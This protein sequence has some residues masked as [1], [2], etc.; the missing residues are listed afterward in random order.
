M[1]LAM[2]TLATTFVLAT[3]TASSLGQAWIPGTPMPAEEYRT[4]KAEGTL[5]PHFRGSVAMPE[6]RHTA[7]TPLPLQLRGGGGTNTCDCWIQ[8][9]GSYTLAMPPDDDNSSGL[10]NLPF[11]FNL[12]GQLFNSVYINNN[13]NISFDSPYVTFTAEPFPVAGFV[14]VAPFWGDV[15]TGGGDGQVWYKTTP[16]ALYVNW[17]GVGYYFQHGDLL[18]SFQLIITDGNDPVIGI[19]KNVSFCY[20]DMQWT[21]GDVDGF[22][23]FGGTPATVGA[24]LGNG[25]DFIQFG[26]FDEPGGAYDGPFGAND[27][28]D[29]LDNQNLVFNTSVFTNNIPPIGSGDYLCDTL[30][31]C[32]GEPVTMDFQFLSPEADQITTATASAPDFSNFTI[33]N[34]VAGQTAH[35]ETQFTPLPTE[36]GY[37]VVTF[38]ATDNGVPPQTAVYN[39]VVNVLVSS[40]MEPGDTV[41]CETSLPLTLFDL[42]GGAPIAGGTWVDPNGDPH[43]GIFSPGE[44]VVG[45]YSYSVDAGAG[46]P[47]TGIVTVSTSPGP[48]AGANGAVAFCTNSVDAALFPSLNGTPDAGGTWTGPGGVA[49]DGTFSPANEPAGIY[50]YTVSGGGAC[51][52]ASATVTVTLEQ[53]PEPGVDGSITLCSSNAQV[54]LIAQLGGTP[55]AGGTWTAPGG[56]ANNGTFNP[57]NGTPGVY[58]Y[59]VTGAAPCPDASA[60]VTVDVVPAPDAGNNAAETLCSDMAAIDLFNSLG[61]TPDAGGAWTAPGGGA[62][63][64][65]FDPSS[66]VAGAYT[67]TVAGTTPCLDDVATVSV[68]VQQAVDAGLDADIILCAD[69][70]PFAM[71]DELAGTPDANGTWSGPGGASTGTFDPADDAAGTYSYTMAAI[72]PCVSQSST[73]GITVDEVPYAGVDGTLAL[74][75]D[76]GNTGLFQ[77]LSGGPDNDGQWL[78]PDGS[79]HNGVVQPDSSASGDYVYLVLGQ[80]TCDHLSDSGVVAVQ[81][82]PIPVVTFMAEPDSGCVPLEVTFTNTTDTL[83]HGVSCIWDFGDG[84]G[85]EAC[86]PFVHEYT[87]E[88]WFNVM[89]TVESEAGCIGDTTIQGAV[90]VDPMPSARF[91]WT[92]EVATDLV[93]TVIFTAA[94]P[95]ATVFDWDIAGVAESDQRQVLHTFPDVQS[96]EYEVCLNVAD[97]YGC[98]DSLCETIS[99]VIPQ[100]FVPNAFSPNG[101]GINDLFIPFLH[102]MVA[103]DHELMIF[104]RWGQSVFTS[105]DP[106]EGWNGG[107]DNSAEPLPNG[108]YMWRL[109]ERPFGTSDKKDW[110]GTVTLLK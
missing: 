23:G 21:T 55:D 63:D 92:P 106:G 66:D 57:N 78:A 73:L 91:T 9:D 8:P 99:V 12:Y 97:R 52:D 90:L 31:I 105:T 30:E 104:D 47:S 19:G 6:A 44:D 38:E 35:I 81:L 86:A 83:Y 109:V 14:M 77:L 27:G 40:A 48:S 107:K 1:I 5:P 4:R 69:A 28:V 94:D 41:V 54:G 98:V 39:I 59:T 22:N 53:L 76:A 24:N 84:N 20:Q 49:E 16:T 2:R 101:D 80:G 85:L 89:L 42:L 36:T 29:W 75:E 50:T 13:G 33:V 32:A 43:T 62:S 61:G 37:H 64:A 88:G 68:T 95:Y 71:L 67:Y 17:V 93:P 11:N 56:V 60:T 15:D 45:A 25:V 58:T 103:Q 87:D 51:A 79:S 70:A 3:I 7:T 18:N 110:F 46:C 34:N 108:L 102:G 74:C 82:F 72:A 26:Q 65:S 10:I 96:G 100:L